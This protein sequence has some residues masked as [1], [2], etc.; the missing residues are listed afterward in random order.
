MPSPEGPVRCGSFVPPDHRT[1]DGRLWSGSGAVGSL[2]GGGP[3]CHNGSIRVR[4]WVAVALPVPAVPL[5][6]PS[7][8]SPLSW[9][10]SSQ[11]SPTSLSSRRRR[12]AAASPGSR[13]PPGLSWWP[14]FELRRGSAVPAAGS[15]GRLLSTLP[16]R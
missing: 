9:R 12:G 5:S 15:P 11:P 2:A 6:W 10:R 14:A 13:P 16:H 8:S 1:A 7:C 4:S 3:G